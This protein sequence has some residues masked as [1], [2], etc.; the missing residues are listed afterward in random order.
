MTET[1]LLSALLLTAVA[2]GTADRGSDDPHADMPMATAMDIAAVG[3][4][5]PEGMLHD[6]V[7]DV[8]LVSNINGGPADKDDNGFISRLAPTGAVLTLK[9]IDGAA[10][11]V[12]LHAPKG[13]AVRGDTLFVADIDAVRLFVRADGAPL[14]AWP[15]DGAAFL[16]DLAVGPDGTLYVS[17]S[18]VEPGESGLVPNGRDGIYRRDGDR[19]TAVVTGTGLGGPNGMLAESA[20]LTVVTFLSGEVYTVDPASGERTMLAKPDAGMLD[21]VVRLADGSLLI[22]SWGAQGVYRLTPAGAFS[23][24]ADSVASPA[25]IAFDATRGAL[26]IPDFLGNRVLIRPVH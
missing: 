16:N 25:D 19:W 21:G 8:Y 11:G 20:G 23:T 6:A 24:T 10:D 7:A 17:D 15:L 26:L 18:G 4:A 14:G 2:C 9:W 22:S 3:F 1:R 5:T 12:T 13:M